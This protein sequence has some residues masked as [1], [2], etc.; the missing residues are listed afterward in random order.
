MTSHENQEYK[1]GKI[2]YFLFFIYFQKWIFNVLPWLVFFPF[3]TIAGLLADRMI[4]SGWSV[5]FVRKFFQTFSMCGTAFCML[6][7]DW[8]VTFPQAMVLIMIT[9]AC[10]AMGNCGVPVTPQDMA[11]K[12][13]GSLFGLMNSAGA[14]SGI[15]LVPISGHVLEITQLWSSIFH[16]NTAILLFGA[17]VFLIFGTAKQIA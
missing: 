13:A 14:F 2:I 11:P 16:I 10:N 17:A 6:L 9:M 15:V 4:K 8:V 5:T 7:F 12:F 3:S 1:P